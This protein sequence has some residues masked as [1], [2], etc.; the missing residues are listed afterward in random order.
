VPPAHAIRPR[1]NMPIIDDLVTAV[2]EFMM[3]LR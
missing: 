2:N 1:Q 3:R